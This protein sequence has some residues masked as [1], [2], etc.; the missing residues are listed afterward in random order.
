MSVAQEFIGKLSDD[1]VMSCSRLPALMGVSG[2]SSPNDEVRKSIAALDA[3]AKGLP[4]PERDTAG[5]AAEWGNRLENEILRTTAQRLKLDIDYQITERVQHNEL[6]LQ[7]S[8]DGI[9]AGD[10]RVIDHDPSAGIYVVGAD[11]ITL[12]G[13]GIAEAKLTGVMPLDEPAAYRGPLQCQGLM[14]C[15]GY[16]WAAIG[17]LYRGTEL[18]IYLMGADPVMQSKIR[19]DVLDFSERLADYQKNG[20]VDWYPALSS[21]DA[22]ST[23]RV[24]EDDLPPI[25]L[26]ADASDLVMDL[27]AARQAQAAARKLIEAAQTQIMDRMALH[28]TAFAKNEDGEVFAEVTWGMSRARKEYSVSAKP[29]KRAGTLKIRE[30]DL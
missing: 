26:D 19:G 23:F 7:G 6:R 28:P 2:F 1:A 21:N 3:R 18:R 25:N 20:V 10:G 17:T 13:P 29:A 8:L 16:K 22:Q 30:L 11:S 4:D 12:D 15:T 24:V 14:M 5:E 9:I 27:I